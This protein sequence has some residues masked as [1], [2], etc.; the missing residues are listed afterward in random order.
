VFGNARVIR[1]TGVLL[2]PGYRVISPSDRTG[3]AH[4]KLSPHRHHHTGT[5]HPGTTTPQQGV[6]MNNEP[7]LGNVLGA[8]V[9][10]LK[11]LLSGLKG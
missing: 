9:G 7:I 2:S 5:T 8:V 10:L 1:L 3:A 4:R 11:G 6:P